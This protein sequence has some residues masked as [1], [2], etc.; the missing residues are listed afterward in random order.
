MSEPRRRP[1]DPARYWARRQQHWAARLKSED[2]EIRARAERWH[3]IA[4]DRLVATNQERAKA[5][6]PIRS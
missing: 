5:A 4:S 1:F 2:P 3:K 6:W